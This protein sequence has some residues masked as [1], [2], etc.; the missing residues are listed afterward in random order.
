MVYSKLTIKTP[1]HKIK[2]KGSRMRYSKFTIKTPEPN[3]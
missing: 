3:C 2:N 1:E